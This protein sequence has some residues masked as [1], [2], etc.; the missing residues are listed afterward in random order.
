[1]N[2][3][4]EWVRKASEELAELIERKG[5]PGVDGLPGISGNPAERRPAGFPGDTGVIGEPGNVYALLSSICQVMLGD[6][7]VSL[8]YV[9][10]MEKEKTLSRSIFVSSESFGL[11]DYGLHRGVDKLK[12]TGV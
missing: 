12:N 4:G 6:F 11:F 9:C 2:R 5:L 8:F 3:N 7:S 10:V 1:M